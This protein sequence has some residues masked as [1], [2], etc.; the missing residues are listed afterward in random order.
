MREFLS[1]MIDE[2]ERQRTPLP[3]RLPSGI[4][5]QQQSDRSRNSSS[6]VRMMNSRPAQTSDGMPDAFLL[7]AMAFRHDLLVTAFKVAVKVQENGQLQ[8][9]QGRSPPQTFQP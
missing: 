9:G 3:E 1:G 2:P 8:S 5:N 6:F 4:G 7:D